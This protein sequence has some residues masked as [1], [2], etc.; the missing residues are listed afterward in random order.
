MRDRRGDGRLPAT[1][2]Y[3]AANAALRP[4]NKEN[5]APS[6]TADQH[7]GAGDRQADGQGGPTRP[8]E[9]AGVA[10]ERFARMASPLPRISASAADDDE[11]KAEPEAR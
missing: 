11:P 10:I 6:A 1:T 3:P 5:I 8:A 7:L 4:T 9:S 2:R